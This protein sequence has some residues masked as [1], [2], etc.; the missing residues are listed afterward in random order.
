MLPN[1]SLMG[2][3]EDG[4]AILCFE[5]GVIHGMEFICKIIYVWDRTNESFAIY[6]QF[7]FYF[8]IVFYLVFCLKKCPTFTEFHGMTF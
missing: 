3:R 4:L 5:S 1:A 6:Y 2:T 7:N 8:T